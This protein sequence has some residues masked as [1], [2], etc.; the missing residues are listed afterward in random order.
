MQTF[1]TLDGEVLDLRDLGGETLTHLRRCY[2]AWRSGATAQEIVDLTRT[3]E[4]P[5][6]R[7][8]GGV[9]TRPTWEHPG[10]RAMHDLETRAYMREGKLRNDEGIDPNADPLD[11]A[12]V[13]SMEAVREKGVT[14]PGLHGA[15]ERGAL[16]AQT[17]D[18][19]GRRRVLVSRN[20]LDAWE[21]NATRQA[22]GR[23]NHT[24]RGGRVGVE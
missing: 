20:S 5:L 6:L 17:I 3:T 22:A 24:N 13:P 16:I 8:T 4:N 18:D 15:I 23:L 21:P 19:D 7:P 10:F 1:R 2:D 12:W 9:M 11:D 14:L